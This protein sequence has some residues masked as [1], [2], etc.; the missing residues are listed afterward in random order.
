MPEAG[1]LR[2]HAVPYKLGLLIITGLKR[3]MAKS[4]SLKKSGP[5]QTADD[6]T[7][8]PLRERQ[9][10]RRRQDLIE[11][12][13]EVFYE[14][15]YILATV[16]DILQRAEISRPTF[17]RYFS[18]KEAVLREIMLEDVGL[19]SLLWRDLAVIGNPSEKQVCAWAVRFL[20]GMRK[21]SQSVALFNIA[22]GLDTTLIHEFSLIRDQNMAVLGEGIK[23]F[24]LKGDG[25][26]K[27]G[28]RRAA[29][30]LLFYQLDQLCF[31]CVF[32]RFDLDEAALISVF[33][34]NFRQ[35]VETYG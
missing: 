27:D 13:R 23:A 9:R 11:A 31:N 34:R 35:F 8:L 29:A 20:K 21:K 32:P 2:R 12:A 18:D 24:S 3:P 14:T 10:Q 17:Y 30:H 16:E 4:T 26:K 19:Q 7:V 25:S 22:C 28:E 6:D 15:H 33:A 1:G 5:I